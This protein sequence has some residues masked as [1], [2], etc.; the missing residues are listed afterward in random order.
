MAYGPRLPF[1]MTGAFRSLGAT[2]GL[3][4]S[5]AIR[6]AVMTVDG[7]E[8]QRAKLPYQIAGAAPVRPLRRESRSRGRVSG[9]IIGQ[10]TD[11]QLLTI[12]DAARQKI[13]GARA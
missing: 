12:T 5:L 3:C 6:S 7:P 10:V 11:T 2:L 4:I 1:R 13:L 8:P 9:R